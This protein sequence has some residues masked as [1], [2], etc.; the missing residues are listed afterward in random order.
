CWRFVAEPENR[1]RTIGL[2]VAVLASLVMAV[3][4]RIWLPGDVALFEAPRLVWPD[5]RQLAIDARRTY[6]LVAFVALAVWWLD[7]RHRPA[8]E[9]GAGAGAR[10]ELLA[11]AAAASIALA[12]ALRSIVMPLRSAYVAQGQA[13]RLHDIYPTYLTADLLQGTDP[14]EFLLLAA[15][16]GLLGAALL[17]NRRRWGALFAACCA[18]I[19]L[20]PI[21]VLVAGFASEPPAQY[22]VAEDAGLY[23]ALGSIPVG[24]EL[25]ISSDLADPSNDYTRPLRAPILTA[26]HGHQFYLS[27]LRYVHYV[28]PDAVERLTE[29][30]QF[31]GTPWSAWHDVW[32][33]DRHITHILVDSRCSPIWLGDANLPLAR[34]ARSGDWTVFRV[35]AGAARRAA[36]H[37]SPPSRWR[38]LVPKTGRADCL[39]GGRGN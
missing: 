28:R 17:R 38:D 14:G 22:A 5:V 15:G 35:D 29:L 24:R 12:L 4:A 34:V 3:A 20:S 32:L 25:L 21:P 36:E 30:R 33:A 13:L 39:L 19:V 23:R 6:S 10:V 27:N 18:L 9:V 2:G 37:V 31:F 11:A 8:S 7:R 16:V 1:A 26:Y